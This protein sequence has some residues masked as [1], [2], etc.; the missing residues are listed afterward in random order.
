MNKIL[1]LLFSILLFSFCSNR[2]AHRGNQLVVTEDLVGFYKFEKDSIEKR[3][4]ILS[5]SIELLPNKIFIYKSRYSFIKREI[6]GTWN[7]DNGN[8]YSPLNSP[9]RLQKIFC[10]YVNENH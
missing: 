8:Y 4:S 7:I 5:E 3:S 1:L 2:Q 6:S 9:T 10:N